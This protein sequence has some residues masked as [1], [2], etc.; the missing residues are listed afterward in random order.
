MRNNSLRVNIATPMAE[1][2]SSN[3]SCSRL[4]VRTSRTRGSSTSTA[5]S[6]QRIRTNRSTCTHRPQAIATPH[7]IP[8]RILISTTPTR[9][10]THARLRIPRTGSI[11]SKRTTPTRTLTILTTR[12]RQRQR[13]TADTQATRHRSTTPILLTTSLNI[14]TRLRRTTSQAQK[15][16]SSDS[17]IREEAATTLTSHPVRDRTARDSP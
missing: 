7:S 11:R 15:S 4:R 9:A 5:R 6:A 8:T 17:P 12:P 3:P 13:Q 1:L 10:T 14:R 2:R 16:S